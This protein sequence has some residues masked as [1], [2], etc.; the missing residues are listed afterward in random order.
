[1]RLLEEVVRTEP[2]FGVAHIDLG[3]SY[4]QLAREYADVKWVSKAHEALYRARSLGMTEHPSWQMAIGTLLWQFEARFDE[5]ESQFRPVLENGAA[6][7]GHWM[8]ASGLVREA[9]AYAEVLVKRLPYVAT[10]WSVLANARALD[11]DVVGAH[12]AAVRVA[13]LIPADASWMNYMLYWTLPTLGR[14]D[15]AE[16]HLA[17]LREQLSRNQ[18]SPYL[19]LMAL[20]LE[21]NLA[22]ARRDPVAATQ[23]AESLANN[24]WHAIAGILY[25]VLEDE[26]ASEELEAASQPPF[27][28]RNNVPFYLLHLPV[29]RLDDPRVRRMLDAMGLTEAWRLEFCRRISD[30][31]RETA[32]D[33][34][35]T[36]YESS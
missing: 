14:L 27:F 2:T 35:P 15:E 7:Y 16:A 34:D 4:I 1:M 19:Q 23:A 21:F 28:R 29:R 26:R 3:W 12:E 18:G 6:V 11:G 5:A 31:P 13:Q 33:C 24:G 17:L 22:M 20:T 32:L 10:S 9:R 30:L 8:L 25:L 36:I